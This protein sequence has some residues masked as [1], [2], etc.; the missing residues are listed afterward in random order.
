MSSAACV[1]QSLT[2]NSRL[3]SELDPS[4][5]SNTEPGIYFVFVQFEGIA[6]QRVTVDVQSDDF[7]TASALSPPGW[8]LAEG[9]GQPL[10][11]GDNGAGRPGNDVRY[12]HTL[13]E[14]GTWTIGVG[15]PQEPG[16]V[17]EYT[18][19][20]DCE[21]PVAA[22]LAPSELRAT[23]VSATEIRLDWQDN[24]TDESEFRIEMRT[25][26]GD[27]ELL[28][29]TAADTSSGNASDLEPGQEYE[30]RVRAQN[31]GGASPWSNQAT[32][33]TFQSAPV[34]CE[35]DEFVTCLS[36]ERFSVEIDWRDFEGGT[37][38]GRVVPVESDDSGLFW[39]FGADNWEMLVKVLDAC[40]I[41]DRFWVFAAATT[42]VEYTLTVTD[43]DTG[44][45]KRYFNPLGQ[46]SPAVT[47][48]D[49]FA[50]CP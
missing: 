32:A 38:R 26:Q 23:P 49:A 10:V 13:D 24:A 7:K 43:T 9:P 29:L 37:G 27:F 11:A 12:Q 20:V 16:G 41:S 14:S 48:S 22:P 42:D 1:V 8:T 17:G 31:G 3:T 50:T 39:F 15:N 46:A 45:V 36:G 2:C 4:V 40:A 19:S 33:A 30:F 28:A 44:A 21:T 35:P 5:C 34:P 25:M 6:G 18:L 47:D